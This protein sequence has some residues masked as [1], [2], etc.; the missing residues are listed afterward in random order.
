MVS[1]KRWTGTMVDLL[2]VSLYLL[3]GCGEKSSLEKMA[4]KILK[5]ATNKDVDVKYFVF[6][7]NEN[8]QHNQD[9]DIKM[10]FG[11]LQHF[12][13]SIFC[14]RWNVPTPQNLFQH[15]TGQFP[16]K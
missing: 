8:N 3:N 2:A 6:W 10:D 12:F 5:H 7:L 9:S 14:W 4:E 1:G 13:C 16:A 11:R 15:R